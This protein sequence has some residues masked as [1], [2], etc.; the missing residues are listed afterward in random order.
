MGPELSPAREDTGLGLGD[1]AVGVGGRGRLA[2][3]AGSVAGPTMKNSLEPMSVEQP[4]QPSA[5]AF[6]SAAGAWTMI[7]STSPF[8]SMSRDWP[9]GL[10]PVQPATG[11]GAVALAQELEQAQFAGGCRWQGKGLGAGAVAFLDGGRPRAGP[12]PGTRS[13]QHHGQ[14]D[15]GAHGQFSFAFGDHLFVLGG[16]ESR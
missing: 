1:L 15:D 5:R 16:K 4:A 12:T 11:L 10:D 6:F 9:S 2:M 13:E 3:P 14:G 8:W 7:M